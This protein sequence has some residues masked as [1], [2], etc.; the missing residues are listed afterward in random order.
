MAPLLMGPGAS[1]A[2][3]APR[4]ILDPPATGLE[5]VGISL[6]RCGQAQ[7]GGQAAT[8]QAT[9]RGATGTEAAGQGVE[10]VIVQ[11]VLRG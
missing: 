8:E 10:A 1:Q 6:I 7:Q 2:G 4:R 11:A 5:A 3:P 9:K